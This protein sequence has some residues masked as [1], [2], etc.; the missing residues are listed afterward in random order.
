MDGAS[1]HV[2]DCVWSQGSC[3][4]YTGFLYLSCPGQRLVF[5]SPYAREPWTTIV[6]RPM[7][8]HLQARN[9]QTCQSS[10]TQRWKDLRLPFNLRCTGMPSPMQP[11]Y[12]MLS[13]TSVLLDLSRIRVFRYLSR[14][15]RRARP[16]IWMHREQ[17]LWDATKSTCVADLE[18][19]NV[20]TK[21]ILPGIEQLPG[22]YALVQ[23]R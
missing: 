5:W 17:S 4:F 3:P 21:S 14:G 22:R 6:K 8:L 9:A 1:V 10:R 12:Q 11:R 19:E 15:A 2:W 18:L 20:K 16:V 7:H 23:D 13:P